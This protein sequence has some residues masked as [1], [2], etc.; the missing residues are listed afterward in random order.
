LEI[1]D[2]YFLSPLAV[3][4]DGARDV[5]VTLER[6]ERGYGFEVSSR[7]ARDKHAAPQLHAQARLVA[8]EHREPARIDHLT[9][10]KRCPNVK[11]A[12]TGETLHTRQEEHLRFGP[13]WRVL[14]ETAYGN[15]EALAC[16]RLPEAFVD[17]LPQY[18]LHP[19]LMDMATGF[20]MDLIEG[21]SESTNLWVPVSYKRVA[22]FGPLPA[23]I[24]SWVRN[25]GVNRARWAICVVR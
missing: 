24:V 7:P 10:A 1:Q 25:H 2:L 15:G 5:T 14:Q 19:A 9:L 11:H 6:D 12:A 8:D 16:L 13:R 3:D 23:A 20:A 21:Y 4:N 22:C 18:G 17:D